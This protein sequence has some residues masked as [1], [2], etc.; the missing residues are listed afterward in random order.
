M[1]EIYIYIS[2]LRSSWEAASP[3]APRKQGLFLGKPAVASGP[4]S[5]LFLEL[6]RGRRSGEE[7]R[8]PGL[9]TK[10]F[11]FPNFVTMGQV[12]RGGEGWAWC[13]EAFCHP[14]WFHQFSEL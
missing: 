1:S 13:G 9:E 8:R 4:L 3:T 10:L 5:L 7:A 6:W 2:V 11:H 14:S 12:G